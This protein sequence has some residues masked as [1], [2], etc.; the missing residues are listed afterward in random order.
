[1]K[2]MEFKVWIKSLD[3]MS[4]SQRNKEKWLNYEQ[5][6]I[7]E[8][9]I[10]KSENSCGIA[11]NTSFN[12]RHRFLRITAIQQSNQMNGIVEA[13]ETYFLESFKG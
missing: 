5:T 1:M 8:L 6:M 12:W 9:S 7:Q 13:D 3:R 11:K 10:R 2:A 4:R